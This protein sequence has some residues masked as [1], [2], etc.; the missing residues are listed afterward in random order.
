MPRGLLL[1]IF[2]PG[3][4]VSRPAFAITTATYGNNIA[5]ANANHLYGLGKTTVRRKQTVLIII[6]MR[7]RRCLPAKS[8]VNPF[9]AEVMSKLS[10]GSDVDLRER[11]MA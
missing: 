8:E 4:T 7:Y 3:R 9:G 1:K 5:P 10:T 11:F 6:E 2:V